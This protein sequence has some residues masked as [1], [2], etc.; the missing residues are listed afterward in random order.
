LVKNI[1]VL[2]SSGKKCLSSERSRLRRAIGGLLQGKKKTSGVHPLVE[3]HYFID[4]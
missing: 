1:P 2:R 4:F 3:Q